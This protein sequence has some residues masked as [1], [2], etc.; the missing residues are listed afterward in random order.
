MKRPIAKNKTEEP[1]PQVEFQCNKSEKDS[2]R[3]IIVRVHST[4]IKKALELPKSENKTKI[5]TKQQLSG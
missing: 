1:L 2:L 3:P 4:K 5:P